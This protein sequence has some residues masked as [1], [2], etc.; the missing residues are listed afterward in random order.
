MEQRVQG[1]QD[2]QARGRPPPPAWAE[3]VKAATVS[4]FLYEFNSHQ[5]VTAAAAA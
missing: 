5:H 4:F 2:L 3:P 1:S